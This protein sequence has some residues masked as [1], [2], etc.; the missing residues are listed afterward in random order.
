MDRFEMEREK[1]VR[2]C[3]KTYSKSVYHKFDKTLCISCYQMENNVT[4][5]K[6]TL[7]AKDLFIFHLKKLHNG[8]QCRIRATN[9]IYVTYIY[10]S[11]VRGQTI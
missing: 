8:K 3:L 11:N 1:N 5:H 10:S 4:H 6:K 7:I 2:V 9:D